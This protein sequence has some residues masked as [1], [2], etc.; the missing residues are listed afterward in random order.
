LLVLENWTGKPV[1]PEEPFIC[2]PRQCGQFSA[3]SDGANKIARVT[4]K[5]EMIIRRQFI[6]ISRV[7]RRS[8][9]TNFGLH[10]QWIYY[11]L[12]GKQDGSVEFS[13]ESI[14]GRTRGIRGQSDTPAATEQKNL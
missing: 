5:S 1:S 9:T 7:K 12:D 4:I 13:P 11:A 2:G 3:R 14:N 10:E 6:F 8:L